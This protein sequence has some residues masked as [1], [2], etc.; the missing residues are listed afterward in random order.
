MGPDLMIMPKEDGND[1]DFL[2]SSVL[3]IIHK[4]KDEEDAQSKVSSL[5]TDSKASASPI[6]RADV[7][8]LQPARILT[9][10]TSVILTSSTKHMISRSPLLLSQGPMLQPACI[11]TFDIDHFYQAYDLKAAEVSASPIPRADVATHF[12]PY[13]PDFSDVDLFYQAYDP[14]VAKAVIED[15]DDDILGPDLNGGEGRH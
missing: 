9:Y 1:F 14:V 2:F 7:A 4:G 5:A 12:H 3:D 13:L 15:L 8:M 10:L 6:P 11:L